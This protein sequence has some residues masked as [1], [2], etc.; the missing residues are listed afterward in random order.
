M[1]WQAWLEAAPRPF[2]L[3]GMVHLPPLPGSPRWGAPW[4]RCSRRRAGTR[5]AV[6][7]ALRE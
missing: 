2:L 3:L 1:R 6:R 7:D 4:P 5:A